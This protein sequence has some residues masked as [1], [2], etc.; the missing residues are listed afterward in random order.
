M[1][2]T[3]SKYLLLL[4]LMVSAVSGCKKNETSALPPEV[5]TEVCARNLQIITQS[6]KL[7]A[8]NN[9]KAAT[10]TPTMEDISVFSR[11]L[12][13]CPGG[14]TYTLGTVA[15][16]PTCSIAAH[17]EAFKKLAANP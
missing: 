11:H 1:R 15:D 7:W 10:D 16:A 12:P 5:G 9:H 3:F 2:I 13:A 4:A 8:E 6:K 17:N 14:G